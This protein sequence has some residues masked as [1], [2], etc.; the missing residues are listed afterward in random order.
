[1]DKKYSTF[2]AKCIKRIMKK[3]EVSLQEARVNFVSIVFSMRIENA[4]EMYTEVEDMSKA[5]AKVLCVTIPLSDKEFL[6]KIDKM[7]PDIDPNDEFDR[8]DNLFSNLPDK[9]KVK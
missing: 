6:D 4:I 3:R 7:T 1:M 2:K 5:D 8:L 9:I